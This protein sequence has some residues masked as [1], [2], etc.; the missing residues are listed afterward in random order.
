MVRDSRWRW[1]TGRMTECHTRC[2]SVSPF[3]HVGAHSPLYRDLGLEGLKTGKFPTW[4]LLFWPS[5]A[6]VILRGTNNEPSETVTSPGHGMMGGVSHEPLSSLT[7]GT[8]GRCPNH[9][10]FS[11]SQGPQ[12]TCMSMVNGTVAELLLQALPVL[13]WVGS[14]RSP[15]RSSTRRACEQGSSSQHTPP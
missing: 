9:Q 12:Q 13:R 11:H 8:L 1:G 4:H 10:S 6:R 3:V 2:Q 15:S 7:P 14:A 5:H